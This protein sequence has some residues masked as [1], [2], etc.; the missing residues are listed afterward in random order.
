MQERVLATLLESLLVI[1]A[2]TGFPH[3]GSSSARPLG[4]EEP[5]NTHGRP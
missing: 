3:C 2:F 1:S 4:L 5:E